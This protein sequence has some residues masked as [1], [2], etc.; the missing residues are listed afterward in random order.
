MGAV[1]SAAGAGP[2]PWAGAGGDSGR[3]GWS[4][5]GCEDADPARSGAPSARLASDRSPGLTPGNPARPQA[6]PSARGRWFGGRRRARVGRPRRRWAVRFRRRDRRPGCLGRLGPGEPPSGR[7]IRPRS[8]PRPQARASIAVLSAWRE[9]PRPP[10][11]DHTA[12]T[13]ER[14]DPAV[15]GLGGPTPRRTD[16]ARH[17]HHRRAPAA[18]LGHEPA[19]RGDAVRGCVVPGGRGGGGPCAG[20]GAQW[21]G[22]ARSG[23]GPPPT[24]PG[25]RPP[26]LRG[27]L[28]RGRPHLPPPVAAKRANRAHTGSA[29]RFRTPR[30]RRRRRVRAPGVEP[31]AQREG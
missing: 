8:R 3:P 17:G 29:G 27:R 5:W 1:G 6:Q 2:C 25:P 28:P 11:A 24:E 26:H 22:R 31:A 19:G 14:G 9:H 15:P 16:P 23:G 10:A 18:S 7:T 12:L 30:L 20:G 13:V 4:A 21:P